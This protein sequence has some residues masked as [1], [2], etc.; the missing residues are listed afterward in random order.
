MLAR[1]G[2]PPHWREHSVRAYSAEVVSG[3]VMLVF[4]LS[5]ALL[6]SPE[7]AKPADAGKVICKREVVTGSN[8]KRKVCATKA[9]WDAR[10]EADQKAMQDMARR[11]TGSAGGGG[12]APPAGPAN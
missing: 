2:D 7:L 12:M 3:A 8:A 4:L 10:R 1:G 5:A 9:E 11:N 6:G